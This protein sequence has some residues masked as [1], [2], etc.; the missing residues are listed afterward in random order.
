MYEREIGSVCMR[1]RERYCVYE[2]DR[3]S[4]GCGCEREKSV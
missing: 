4:R 2:I 1:E 3:D